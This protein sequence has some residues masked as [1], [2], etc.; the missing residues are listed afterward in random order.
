[1][2][3]EK[4]VHQPHDKIV[5]R[6][7]SN[8]DAARDILSLYLPQ[9]ILAIV[10]LNHLELQK[11]SFIDDEHRAYAADLLYK[12]S[13]QDKEG[14]IWVLLE[15]QRESDYW[16]P[17]RLF[18]YMGMIWDHVRQSSQSQ[19]LPLV[20]PL[21]IFNGDA[22]YA[23][24]LKL[25]DLIQPEASKSIFSQLFMNPFT[26]IDLPAIKDDSLRQ[27]AQKSLKG[28]ALLMTL[29]HIYDKHLQLFYET[30][31]LAILKKLDHLGDANA[32]SDLLYYLLKE[33]EFL[34]E[35]RFWQTFQ[36]RF[37]QEVENKMTTIAQ[38]MEQRAMEKGVQSTK[39]EIAQ[40]LLSEEIG[41]SK[42]AL[43]ALIQRMTGLSK[44]EIQSLHKKH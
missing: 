17:L 28:V 24:S 16:M 10:D 21:V 27:L 30:T 39:F 32:V 31:L 23:H 5:K 44:N 38:K 34:N 11:D 33:G 9:E 3:K 6:M 18:K 26:L 41:L 35:E 42:R 25:I 22:P 36:N 1:M 15:H 13:C 43:I 2:R 40:K 12:T 4:S 19:Y 29:K 14:Y 8:P 20:Y 37:S 7:L